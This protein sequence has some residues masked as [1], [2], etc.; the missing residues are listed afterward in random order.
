MPRINADLLQRIA[1]ELGI[2]RKS[3]YDRLYAIERESGLEGQMAALA[4]AKQLGIGIKRFSTPEQRAVIAR[5]PAK[6][7]QSIIETPTNL[8]PTPTGKLPKTAKKRPK[9]KENTV[10]VVHGRDTKLKEAMY[11]FLGSLGLRAQEWGHALKAARGGNPYVGDAVARIMEKAQAVVV[12]FSPDDEVRLK[13]Q[14]LTRHERSSEGRLRGQA[15]PNVLFE[16]G[17]AIGSHHRKTILVEIGKVK[18]FSDIGGMHMLRL[19]G[20]HKSRNDFANRLQ[21]VGCT[22]DKIGDYWLTAGDF[23]PTPPKRK[24]S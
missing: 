14:F 19:T 17:V 13:D 3:V 18:S 8:P 12:M 10:F 23:M 4:L 7:Q 11:Q 9:T 5:G 6:N 15:R 2:E 24:K 1:S 16:A 20:D 21:T 22:V